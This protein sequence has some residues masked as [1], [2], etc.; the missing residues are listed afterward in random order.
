MPRPER[1][2][3][4]LSSTAHVDLGVFEQRPQGFNGG[5]IANSPK[6]SSGRCAHP[7]D[8][9]TQQLGDSLGDRQ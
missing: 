3:A 1:I 5:C 9:V 6:R 8:L 2:E 7:R 4:M